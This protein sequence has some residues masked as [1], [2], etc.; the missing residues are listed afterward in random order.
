MAGVKLCIIRM[1]IV[2]NAEFA[3]LGEC[4]L[5]ALVIAVFG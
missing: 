1:K 5:F 3:R 2:K 4:V